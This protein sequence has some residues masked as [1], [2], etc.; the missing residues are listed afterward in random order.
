[1]DFIETRNGRSHVVLLQHRMRRAE[2]ALLISTLAWIAVAVV[3]VVFLCTT[4]FSVVQAQSQKLRVREL[5]I[6]D[7]KGRERIVIASPLPD[8]IV[9]GKV[10][11]RIRVVSAA[12]QF[13]APDGTEQGGIALSDDGS[14]MFGIDDESG[15]ERAHLYYIPTR[16]SGV[17][18]Q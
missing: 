14:F 16:G 4:S 2:R 5:D 9:N 17:Y 8:P 11:H 6:V 7:Q 15:R 13:K 1:M 3:G 10:G 12:V 18:L